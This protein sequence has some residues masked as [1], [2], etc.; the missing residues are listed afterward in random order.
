VTKENDTKKGRRCVEPNA[1]GGPCG[2]PPLRGESYCWSHHPQKRLERKRAQQKGTAIRHSSRMPA[3]MSP[4]VQ[5]GPP[6]EG[7]PVSDWEPGKP[8]R[9]LSD[10]KAALSDLYQRSFNAAMEESDEKVGTDKE[11]MRPLDAQR[12]ASV[13]NTFV[14]T[15][16]T[17]FRQRMLAWEAKALWVGYQT[18]LK[19]VN[20]PQLVHAWADEVSRELGSAWTPDDADRAT[21]MLPEVK[22]V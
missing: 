8:L 21:L 22:E 14:G 20:D 19:L 11:G 16:M 7:Y 9:N 1:K 5:D 3:N 13:V 10:A 18:L 4:L 2:M 15:D 6:E 12:I 17:E